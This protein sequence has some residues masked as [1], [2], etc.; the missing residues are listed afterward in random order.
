MITIKRK[1]TH[2]IAQTHYETVMNGNPGKNQWKLS[3]HLENLR[4]SYHDGDYEVEFID[5]LLED[6]EMEK[7]DHESSI[8]TCSPKTLETK[9]LEYNQ[10]F[11]HLKGDEDFLKKLGKSFFYDKYDRWNAYQLADQLQVNVCPYCN[12]QFTFTVGTD[13]NKITRPQY[14]HFIN[15]AKAP[16]FS[17]SFYNLIPS[18]STCNSGLK[19]D[20]FLSLTKYI[21]PYVD[22]TADDVLFSLDTKDIGFLNGKASSYSITVGKSII[23][24]ASDEQVDKTFETYKMFKVIEIY[25]KH[26]DYVD[27]VI[28]KSRIYN[29]A[30]I[31]LIYNQYKGTLF[32]DF[33]EAKR[34]LYSNYLL[35]EELEKRPLAKLTRDIVAYIESLKE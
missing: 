25:Q 5:V 9:Y 23:S 6:I 18:C 29:D 34:M 8:I 27:E 19:G 24:T 3:K 15:K 12:R 14:D 17:L 7:D 20:T 10:K 28:K 1:N 21:H 16:Y 2:S 22:D 31:K 32:N 11:S 26:K 4:G 35:S 30:N 33:H 13:L